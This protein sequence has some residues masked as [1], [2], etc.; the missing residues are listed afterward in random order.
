[1][2]PS[3]AEKVHLSGC[4][5]MSPLREGAESCKGICFSC[6]FGKNSKA[7]ESNVISLSSLCSRKQEVQYF[8]QTLQKNY[9]TA[10]VIVAGFVCSN[11]PGKFSLVY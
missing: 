7:W 11:Y 2:L 8:L 1:M 5:G 4:K 9:L 3:P 6:S 10:V